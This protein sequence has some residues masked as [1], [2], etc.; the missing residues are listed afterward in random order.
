MDN[1]LSN[2]L[3]EKLVM[4][5]RILDKT[6]LTVPFGHVSVRE[7]GS[8]RLLISRAIAPGLVKDEDLLLVDR[9]VE[10]EVEIIADYRKRG[11]IRHY[12]IFADEQKRGHGGTD[13]APGPLEHFLVGAAF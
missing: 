1:G 2:E 5:N 9:I 12:E 6:G 8:D 11:K 10:A 7:P 3:I 4:A 13:T